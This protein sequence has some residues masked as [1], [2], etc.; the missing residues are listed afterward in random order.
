MRKKDI[1]TLL[2]LIIITTLTAIIATNFDAIKYIS[3]TVLG[4]SV[5]KFL[6]IAFQFME[7][8][9][10]HIFWKILLI[11]YLSIFVLIIGVVL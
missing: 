6:A 7:L 5:I 1:Y 4:L 9:K 10:A 3:L 11:T 2:I 8:K